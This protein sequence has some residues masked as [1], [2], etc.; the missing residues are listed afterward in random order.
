MAVAIA[1][2]WLGSHFFTPRPAGVVLRFLLPVLCSG[3]FGR[4][5]RSAPDQEVSRPPHT[6]SR[7][8]RNGSPLADADPVCALH[9]NAG[10]EKRNKLDKRCNEEPKNPC[11]SACVP[12]SAAS[13]SRIAGWAGRWGRLCCQVNSPVRLV[14]TAWLATTH[15]GQR[16]VATK[17]NEAMATPARTSTLVMAPQLPTWMLCTTHQ[18]RSKN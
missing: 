10:R 7:D 12:R 11:I 9:R 18:K 16:S 13:R 3:R 14:S 6:T 4:R 1:G 15:V 17:A 2:G 8:C 5:D